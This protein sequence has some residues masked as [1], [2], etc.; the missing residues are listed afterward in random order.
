MPDRTTERRVRGH[1][2]RAR[3]D[4]LVRRHVVRVRVC[5]HLAVFLGGGAVQSTSRARDG[6]LGSDREVRVRDLRR[7]VLSRCVVAGHDHMSVKLRSWA[8]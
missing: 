2:H 7:E 1:E 5:E 4:L 3:G 6:V 8:A